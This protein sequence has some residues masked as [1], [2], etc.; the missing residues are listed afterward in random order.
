[1]SGKAV[2]L[3]GIFLYSNEPRNLVEWYRKNFGLTFESNPD[4][5]AYYL[6][7]PYQDSEGKSRYNVLS[8]IKSK[9][10]RPKRNS[11]LFTLNLR[12]NGI[13]S[14]IDR[15]R[16]NGNKLKPMEVHEEGKFAWVQDPEGNFIE[17]WEE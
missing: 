16:E 7:F 13:E 9:S 10:V 1:M 3:G 8:V 11:K 17:I 4:D 12:V 5:K 14:I 2:Q 15:L 6:S